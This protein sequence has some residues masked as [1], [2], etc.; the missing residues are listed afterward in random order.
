MNGLDSLRDKHAGQDGWIVGLGP[1]IRYLTADYFGSGPIVTINNAILKV[2]EF[3]IP[4]EMYSFQ[5][6]GYE[7]LT[8]KP[9]EHVNLI[10]QRVLSAHW[11]EDQPKRFVIDPMLE[12]G[13]KVTEMSIRI[14]V[15]LVKLMGCTKISFVCCD[16]LSSEEYRRCDPSNSDALIDGQ[17]GYYAYVKPLVQMDVK[18]IPHRFIVPEDMMEVHAVKS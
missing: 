5:K 11:Y 12:W 13:F 14:A 7:Y 1:S 2:Q 15:A 18:N 10:L 3:D 8:V 4:N 6:D 17:S 16:S 9:K